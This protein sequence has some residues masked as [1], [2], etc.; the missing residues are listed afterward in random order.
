MKTYLPT[1]RPELAAQWA[2]PYR[3]PDMVTTGS[4][5]KALWRC[6]LGH[7]WRAAVHS[8]TA[9]AGCPVCAGRMVWPGFNDLA[10]QYPD[11]LDEW[12]D[13]RA[14]SEILAASSYKAVWRC[15]NGHA[16]TAAVYRRT[17]DG[18]GCPTC[19]G[20]RVEPG[21]NDLAS[22]YPALAAEWDDTTRG[23]DTVSPGSNIVVSWKCAQ[24]H[25][26]AMSPNTRVSGGQG[27]PV[28]A[29]RR[30]EPGHNDLAS[31]CPE[32]L[33]EWNDER[34]PRTISPRSASYANW[35]CAKGHTWNAS[36][37]GRYLNHYGCPECNATNFVSA[38]ERE[39]TGFVESLLPDGAV[40]TS[41]RRFR[42]DGINELDA[43]VPSKN[44]A[45]EA[46][47]VFFHSERFRSASY[48]HDKT[49]AC[50]SLGIRLIQVWQDDWVERRDIVERLL[51]RKLG[52]S[53]ERR[54][55]A[56]KTTAE[57]LVPS[58]AR[59]F[60]ERNHIQGAASA[61]H[62]L[63][64]RDDDGTLVAVMALKRTD[65]EGR[66]LRLERYATSAIVPGGHSKLV[67]FAEREIRGW[68]SLITFADNE[69]SDGS[70]YEATGWVRDGVIRPDY[71]YLVGSQRVHKFNYRL[72]RFRSDSALKYEEGLSERELAALNGLDRVWDSGKVRYRYDRR[73]LVAPL[74][75]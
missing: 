64:L 44:I 42:K 48:H 74:A 9:G 25:T 46:N 57:F 73:E 18:Q 27:C 72:A 1:A 11:F 22:R 70:L 14:P 59:P 71:R 35:K 45:V 39:V 24:G 43:F 53:S 67:S 7:E 51:A 32:L 23:P 58:E 68:Q 38:F 20:R 12:N 47:G 55:A 75:P 4:G 36:I 65:A 63:G 28:C 52:V 50:E 29:N 19:K 8:R 6:T 21:F 30:V 3:D 37:R 49:A 69:V 62:Y 66:V 56:R 26:W 15:A 33:A 41:V 17:V 16:W 13:E 5:Y 31:Q 10:S 61:S 60:L 54:V 34:D 2:D 40:Q